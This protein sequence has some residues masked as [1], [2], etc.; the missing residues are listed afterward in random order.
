M[1]EHPRPRPRKRKL[2]RI[3]QLLPRI[4]SLER[5]NKESPKPKDP[6]D[7]LLEKMQRP[8]LIKIRLV[9]TRKE[10]KIQLRS[11]NPIENPHQRENLLSLQQKI[12]NLKIESQMHQLREENQESQLVYQEN[13]RISKNEESFLAHKF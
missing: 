4:P 3:D 2:R 8:K 10:T 12:E 7:Q 13:Q 1:P 5:L 11:L 9:P 6:R